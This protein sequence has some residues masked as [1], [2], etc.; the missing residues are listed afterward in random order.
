[1]PKRRG[2]IQ[3]RGGVS[4]ATKHLHAFTTA[5]ESFSS[6]ICKS[7]G[8]R[9]EIEWGEER[10]G[11]DG[12]ERDR[13]VVKKVGRKSNRSYLYLGQR[14]G[15]GTIGEVDSRRQTM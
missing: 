12:H 8:W 7:G 3:A 13:G 6:K 15:T 9:R 14:R 4:A 10:G 5:G 11:A 2:R 1:M